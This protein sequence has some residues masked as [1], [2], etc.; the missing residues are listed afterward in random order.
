MQQ[1]QAQAQVQQQ[2]HQQ[3]Q[4]Q[5]QQQQTANQFLPQLNQP[6][7]QN[8][9]FALDAA[10]YDIFRLV[11]TALRTEHRQVLETLFIL[12][13]EFDNRCDQVHL[14][15]VCPPCPCHSL[16]PSSLF[17]S[18]SHTQQEYRKNQL[19]MRGLVEP[20]PVPSAP[21]A[22]AV[23]P[24][25]R[26]V[27]SHHLVCFSSFH[28]CCCCLSSSSNR[29][30]SLHRSMPHL[31]VL[32]AVALQTSR[33]HSRAVHTRLSALAFF[34]CFFSCVC[35]PSDSF[36]LLSLLSLPKRCKTKLG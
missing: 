34:S 15:C 11:D 26:A 35:C 16:L 10:V 7:V 14:Y 18:F 20:I 1:A 33:D 8:G 32:G 25:D 24:E 5:Q 9:R 3:Q 29:V 22:P 21:G 17:L 6:L 2:Q 28:G 13:D 36:S 30:N 31:I 4:H 27:C 19:D 23:N 12:L